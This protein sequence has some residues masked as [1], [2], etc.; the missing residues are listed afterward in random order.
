LVKRAPELQQLSRDHHGALNAALKLRRADDGTA[1]EAAEHFRRFWRE[2]GERH[3]EIEEAVLLPGFVAAG[4]DARDQLV[5]S[6]L[7]DHVEIRARARGLD[8]EDPAL[9]D[10]NELG[11]RLARHVRLE[12]D[13]LFPLIERTLDP[14][15]LAALGEELERAERAERA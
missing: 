8:R 12:E 7:T 11:E 5:A 3:F 1:A 2:H 13:E 10:L 6:V 4:G 14:G 9:A 15:S